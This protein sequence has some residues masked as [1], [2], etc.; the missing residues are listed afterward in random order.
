MS[1]RPGRSWA[2]A[3]Y[4]SRSAETSRSLRSA[5]SAKHFL[6]GGD[7]RCAAMRY[8]PLNHLPERRHVAG[9]GMLPAND[10]SANSFLGVFGDTEADPPAHRV[11][12]KSA[13][14]VPNASSTATTSITLCSS[15]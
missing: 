1:S 11:A 5:D 2:S 8:P 13:F 9:I 12:P 7:E 6:H 14:A 3:R 4:A 10:Q 15:K